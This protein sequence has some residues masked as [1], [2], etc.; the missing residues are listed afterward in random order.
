VSCEASTPIKLRRPAEEN[1]VAEDRRIRPKIVTAA[2]DRRVF[3]VL[4]LYR[5]D[6]ALLKR[7]LDSLASQ[8]FRNFEVLAAADGP[9]DPDARAVVASFAGAPI[10]LVESDARVGIHANFA[11]G[12]REAL[13]GSRSDKDLFAF[14]DQDDVWHSQKLERQVAS[15]AD[16]QVSLCHSNA[17]IVSPQGE[18]L[19]TSLFEREA[20]SR[21]ASF[22]DLMILNSVS[23]MTAIFRRDVAMAAAPFPLS[24]NRYFLHDHWTAL[25][26]SLL[27]GVHFIDEPLVNYTQHAANV[28]GAR[29]WQRTPP[30]QRTSAHRKYLRKCYREYLWRRRALEELR[31]MLGHDPGAAGKLFGKPVRALFDC[32]TGWSPGLAMSIAYRLR[33]ERRQADQI[34][35]LWRGKSLH[36]ASTN[37]R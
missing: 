27:G 29:P 36:C 2:H 19:A 21:R 23:G 33:G 14:C 15:F 32:D 37:R 35:R 6:P 10:R 16:P 18:V 22:A 25:V 13:A 7:Q 31:G 30:L 5:P 12:L 1:G 9:L 28:M 20:R 34:W 24:R 11:R 8:T 3:V 26:A 17:R 4:G